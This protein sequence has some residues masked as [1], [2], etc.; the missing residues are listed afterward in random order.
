MN[1]LNHYFGTD[2][3]QQP[4][5]KLTMNRCF[6]NELFFLVLVLKSCIYSQG[7]SHK[8]MVH[9]DTFGAQAFNFP[10]NISIAK[11]FHAKTYT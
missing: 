3:L 10:L 7:H 11:M 2:E 8:A 5:S 1:L 6:E 4:V 9:F